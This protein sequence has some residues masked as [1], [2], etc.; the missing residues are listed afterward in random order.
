MSELKDLILNHKFSEWQLDRIR[1]DFS[2]GDDKRIQI[3]N[4]NKLYQAVCPEDLEYKY[5]EFYERETVTKTE[6]IEDRNSMVYYY[7]SSNDE[8]K[9]VCYVLEQG[10]KTLNIVEIH[11]L[12]E[13][14][15][16]CIDIMGKQNGEYFH[17]D[18]MTEDR[19]SVEY[20]L[21]FGLKE[22]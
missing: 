6:A 12:N 7:K 2:K 16:I 9:R 11:Q 18:F 20:L 10:D 14:Y 8:Y 3:C 13:T 15:P 4:P 5:Y 19:P 22:L 17:V 21:E 1:L